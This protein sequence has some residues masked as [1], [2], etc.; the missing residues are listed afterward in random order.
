MWGEKQE[1]T[2][3]WYGLIFDKKH[4]TAGADEL[5]K[6]WTGKYPENRAPEVNSFMVNGKVPSDN[7]NISP[8]KNY[9]AEI[10]VTDETKDL[11]YVWELRH[12]STATSGGGDAEA[13]PPIV[14]GS[15]LKIEQNGKVSFKAPAEP[16]KYRLFA[17]VYDQQGKIAHANCPVL[18]K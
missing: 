13:I 5:A 12:E 3:T 17:Y 15:I 7:I 11:K 14:E 8:Q 16:G 6:A 4:S 9:S 10:K 1:R 2:K 18:V